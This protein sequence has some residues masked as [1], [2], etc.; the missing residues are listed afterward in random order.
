MR[1]VHVSD[2]HNRNLKYHSEYRAV[3]KNL[4]KF[5]DEIKPDLIVNT[6]DTGHTKTQISPEFVELTSELLRQL[7][8]RAKVINILGNHDLN[9]MNLDRQD[10]LTPI[11]DSIADPRI[12]LWK[13]S[14]MYQLPEFPGFRF[15]VFSL[16]D[17]ENYPT[18]EQWRKYPEDVNIGLFH[19]S[20]RS[21]VTDSNW[22]MTH[23]EH[24]ADIFQD[25]DYVLMGDIHKQQFIGEG[26]RIAYAGSLIQQNF[27]EDPDKGVLVWDIW[28]KK[29]HTVTPK[30]LPGSRKF[31]TVKLTEE[32]ELPED[33][34]V[35]PGA[36]LRI[37]PP[38][39]L[40]L[41]QQKEIERLARKRF[42]PH[43]L[44]TLSAA[45]ITSSK[46]RVAK[47]EV[48]HE[49]IRQLAV[50]ERLLREYLAEKGLKQSVIDKAIDLNRKYQISIEQNDDSARNVSW[51]INKISWNNLFNYGEGNLIDF[52]CLGGL[53][54][55]FAPNAS[56]KSNLIDTILETCFDG[57]TR[58]LTKN[59]YLINDNKEASSMVADV[60]ANG[61]DYIIERSIERVKTKKDT[62]GKTTA[63]FFAVDTAG[64]Q[65]TLNGDTRP[66]TER[67]IRQRLGTYEDALLTAVSA[68]WNPLDIIAC[69]ETKRKEILYRFLDLDIFEQKRALA[70]EESKQYYEQLKAL[71]DSGLEDHATRLQCEVAELQGKMTEAEEQVTVLKD[72]MTQLNAKSLELTGQKVKVEI[73][74]DIAA[75]ALKVKRAEMEVEKLRKQ[76]SEKQD[77]LAQVQGELGKLDKLEQKFDLELHE[78]KVA[79]L[80]EAEVE[81]KVVEKQLSGKQQSANNHRKGVNLLREVPCGDQF[82][83]C[84][85]LIDAFASKEKLPGLETEVESLQKRR[86]ELTIEVSELAKFK[87][88]LESYQ[89]FIGER[90]S[91]EARRDNLK[92]QLENIVLKV[93]SFD[94]EKAKA[95]EDAARYQKAEDDI[96]KNNELDREIKAVA[97]SVQEK[98]RELKRVQDGIVELS[99]RVGTNQGI[100]EK[101]TEQLAAMGDIR[102]I[103]NAFEHF[104]EAMGKDG[105]AYRILTRKLPIINEEIN[106][107][108]SSTCQF[109]VL[110]EHD[111]EEQSIRLYI[112][113]GEYK[114]RLIELG[115][116][117]EKMLAS[118]ALRAALMNVSSIPKPNFFVIDEGFGKLDAEKFESVTKMFDYLKTVFDHVI[119]ISH[120]ETMRDVVDNV[121][122]ITADEEGYAHVEIGG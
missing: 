7:A 83:Q 103:C 36:H 58:G 99:R 59:I 26:K 33:V 95:L 64:Q 56:G 9:L 23:T 51:R 62:W 68:Q 38:R 89:K 11:V 100:L 43:D 32:L 106:K 97:W 66:E 2:I 119:V 34:H 77:S 84:K 65:E 74:V 105:I 69:K 116:G 18:P 110:I 29:E 109:N 80:A 86:D 67:A 28:N 85:F 92:L 31:Y 5:I 49:D 22:R 108:L 122:E 16:A 21:C 24:D 47:Q 40:T 13:K 42:N 76:V 30:H 55:I 20:I 50:Q 102:T 35:E 19:G 4:Y 94:A 10:A 63:N 96:K 113:Y 70:K 107:I 98:E 114:M 53:T 41:A 81:L 115:S 93:E 78:Q 101:I 117:A 118:I 111:N 39:E 73:D 120:L 14:G 91:L 54:G 57:T 45:N 1:I 17:Q 37:S 87:S 12:M 8:K 90:S 6:G 44:I 15:W 88:K 79:R 112:Q 52:S 48:L 61:Q 75:V 46:S 121:I 104:I 82:P 71:E 72:E 25:L 60:T 27:G 3:F